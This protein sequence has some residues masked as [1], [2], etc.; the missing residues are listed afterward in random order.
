MNFGQQNE[1]VTSEKEAYMV[2]PNE[3]ITGDS[4]DWRT[5]KKINSTVDHTYNNLKQKTFSN[6]GIWSK[7]GKSESQYSE[8]YDNK[9][10][11]VSNTWD[12]RKS[13]AYPGKGY[14]KSKQASH[15]RI[16]P[17]RAS[18]SLSS[19]HFNTN[20][21]NLSK[22]KKKDSQRI[23]KID[24]GAKLITKNSSKNIKQKSVRHQT[25]HSKAK[26]YLKNSTIN[27]KN[28]SATHLR[29]MSYVT[30]NTGY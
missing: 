29:N 26:Q 12:N 16:I 3:A 17:T 8:K 15:S 24:S 14:S 6:K 28:V 23:K 25:Y 19:Y 7:I 18:S 4:F 1:G 9:R 13:T 30:P 11:E 27:K 20:R 22:C 21:S 2:S 10:V 5:F